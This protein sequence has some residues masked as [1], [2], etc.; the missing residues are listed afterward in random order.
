MIYQQRQK[1]LC[2]F[3]NNN[4]Q[5]RKSQVTFYVPQVEHRFR[6]S[7]LLFPCHGQ[8]HPRLYTLINNNLTSQ[9]PN[10]MNV[11]TINE[12]L[13]I[14]SITNTIRKSM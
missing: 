11:N 9:C 7:F 5:P 12:F 8:C 14:Q 13:G 10:Y 3:L 6:L 1:A 4:S 2:W